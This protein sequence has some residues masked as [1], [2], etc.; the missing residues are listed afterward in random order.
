MNPLGRLPAIAQYSSNV[1]QRP[2][3]TANVVV[4]YDTHDTQD[5]FTEV[6]HTL[7]TSQ[8]YVHTPGSYAVFFGGQVSRSG[9]GG[10]QHADYWLRKNGIDIPHSSV[11]QTLLN[12]NDT[13]VLVGN[14]VL[15]LEANDYIEV[16]QAVS[17]VTANMGL[18]V[19]ATLAGGPT[20]PSII[21]TLF[22][23]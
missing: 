10:I 2:V 12:I 19:L 17:S 11:R 7:G 5:S 21:F 9:A 18:T 8:V 16:V 20:T 13:A 4:T 22:R 23:L 3:T 14:Y 6:V 1:S 15:R